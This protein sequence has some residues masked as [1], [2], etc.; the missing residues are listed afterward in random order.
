LILRDELIGLFAT[1]DKD[2][3]EPDRAF[4]LEAW[5]GVRP[6]TSDRIGRGT[7]FVENLCVSLFGGI[8]PAKLHGY[9]YAAKRGSHNDGM[10]QR[11]QIL[12]YPDEPRDWQF[13]DTPINSLAKQ[14]AYRAVER[15]ASMDFRQAGAFGE[16]GQRIPYYRFDEAA[17]SVFNE[18]LPELETKLRQYDD[19][20]ILLEH[21]GKY[22]SLMPALALLFHLLD[23]A[24]GQPAGQ[25]RKE[26]AQRAAAWCD[27]L[28]SHARRIYGLVTNIAEQAAARL[29]RKL[30]EGKLPDI[31]TA[32]DVLR[33]GWSLL[34]DKQVIEHA[35]EELVSRGWLRERVTL[36]AF[37]QRGKTEYLVN[38][39]VR[40][41]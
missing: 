2:G 24:D 10:V 18:W 8:Q 11:L 1:W 15:L 27:Y 13:I 34:D 4:Y 41:C 39:K 20:P 38:P 30:T 23:L 29:A 14:Q 28:E 19:E 21:L 9:L 12:V 33:K 31:F 35:C 40:A 22:R 32:R 5:N 3:H 17:Q 25:V 6:Y 36:P 16:D 26:H 7:I 37:G